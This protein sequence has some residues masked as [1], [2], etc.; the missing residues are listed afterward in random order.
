MKLQLCLAATCYR[1][2][3]RLARV[4]KKPAYQSRM[5]GEVGE[6]IRKL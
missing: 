3:R 5:A 4:N 6:L 1:D 2:R